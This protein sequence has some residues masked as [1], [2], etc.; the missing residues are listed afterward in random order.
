[1]TI[2]IPNAGGLKLTQDDRASLSHSM[3]N[4]Q[5][6]VFRQQGNKFKATQLKNNP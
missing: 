5:L 3:G 4:L 2:Y 1:M 6:H